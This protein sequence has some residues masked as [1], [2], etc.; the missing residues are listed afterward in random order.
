MLPGAVV[1]QTL[2]QTEARVSIDGSL[3]SCAPHP[4]P[5][6]PLPV[7]LSVTDNNTAT[8]NNANNS[9]TNKNNDNN[10]NIK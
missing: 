5:S 7:W 2:L 4:T 6:H 9:N 1:N 10:N 3:G 8:N